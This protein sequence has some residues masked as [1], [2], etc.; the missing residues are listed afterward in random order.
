MYKVGKIRH[1]I[2]NKNNCPAKVGAKR[3]SH[4]QP[5][6]VVPP[7]PLNSPS[8]VLPIKRQREE[9][10]TPF[11][12]VEGQTPRKRRK[13]DETKH[14]TPRKPSVTTPKKGRY[15]R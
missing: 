13:I 10:T 11:T 9:E 12:E 14:I 4:I 15:S 2:P 8:K 1:K 3:Y 7:A 6:S 5:M